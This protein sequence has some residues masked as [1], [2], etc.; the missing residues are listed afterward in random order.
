[1]KIFPKMINWL[2]VLKAIPQGEGG[3]G[4]P[5]LAPY[6]ELPPMN[7][8]CHYVQQ[9][10]IRGKSVHTDWRMEVDDHLVG[11]TVLTPGGIPTSPN[12]EAEGRAAIK[13]Y[14]KLEF[15]TANKNQGFRAETKARQPK[16][17]LTV[18]GVVKPG[19][20][21]ATKEH[22]GVFIIV[23][24]GKVYFGTQ[25]PYF[26]EYFI[27][28]EKENGPF[29]SNDWTRVVARA[30]NVN[31][32]DPETKQPKEGTELMWRILVPGDQI[33]Y[34][35]DR[36]FKKK[37]IPPKNYIPI[38]PDWRKGEK[39]D[40]WEQW[41]KGA[42]SGKEVK[43][44][45]KSRELEDL[46]M[47][48]FKNFA[49][50]VIQTMKA[51]G[52]GEE[53]AKRYCGAIKA[54]IEG[55]AGKFQVQYLSYMGQVVVRGIPHQRWFLRLQEGDKIYSWAADT[56]FTRMS[57]VALEFEGTVEKKW[58]G[59][60]GDIKPN[61][62]YNP[63]K[64]LTAHMQIVDS[65]SCTYETEEVEGAQWISINFKGKELKGKYSVSQEEKDSEMY[66]IEQL[67]EE[68]EKAL[69]VL[70]IHE[71]ETPYGLK[72]HWDVRIDKGFEFNLYQDPLTMT[73][74][75]NS[76]QAVYKLC[77]DIKEWMAIDKPKTKMMV[78]NLVTYVTPVDR[79]TVHLIDI[80]PPGFLSM[81]FEGDKLKGYFVYR[82]MPGR[83]GFFER[84]KLP[85]P[86]SRNGNP[87]D[88]DFFIPFKE[89]KKEGWDYF[90]V[91]VFDQK[92]FS[93]CVTNPETYI[94]SLS[95]KP[96]QVQDVL[97]CLYPR[98]GQLEGARVS[99]IKFSNEWTFEQASKWI[100]DEKLHTWA[101]ELIREEHKSIEDEALAKIID[102]E[103]RRKE[104]TPEER[105]IELELKKKKLQSWDLLLI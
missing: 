32:I 65:G 69:F 13:A 9:W 81:Q 11:W 92:L 98:P 40:A 30:I 42:W 25:K 94:P 55:S 103:L 54:I 47:G 64:T 86:L 5:I 58:W 28:S 34:A 77:R 89:I 74:E 68:L 17:W 53:R 35:I 95:G 78:G 20:V 60:E 27:K 38:P 105:K 21:G 56:D 87:K 90:W 12:T 75:G 83:G 7:K 36:G 44:E 23:D 57:P 85:H 19:Q 71:I 91:E 39:Y 100:K 14:G 88:G 48:K 41:V 104:K 26:H 29:S 99:R 45:E 82:D 102:E 80:S 16:V 24:K 31:V 66:T 50:C 72:K 73:Q 6:M 59:F 1:M 10:H 96:S 101:G 61:S 8:E 49:D 22:P 46:P 2:E 84:A 63:S 3:Q 93:K 33:P 37:W 67:H 18:E 51:K 15:S 79:G 52:W 97:I 4:G 70:Q 43:P 62:E 76:C